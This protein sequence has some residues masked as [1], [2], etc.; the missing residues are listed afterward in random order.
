MEAAA[1]MS[2]VLVNA[3]ASDLTYATILKDYTAFRDSSNRWLDTAERTYARYAR[4]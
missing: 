3:P 1:E 2:R 4:S